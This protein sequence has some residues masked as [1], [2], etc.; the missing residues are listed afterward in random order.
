MKMKNKIKIIGLISV[1]GLVTYF[2]SKKT[3][4]EESRNVSEFYIKEK[5]YK[6]NIFLA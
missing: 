5:E 4:K 1:S 6:E 2:F 3:K